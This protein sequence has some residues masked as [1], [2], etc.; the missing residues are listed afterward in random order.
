MP[1]DQSPDAVEAQTWI[2]ARLD[3]LAGTAVGKIDAFF[4]DE[5][6]GRPEWLVVRLGRF[7]QHGL[8]PAREAVGVAGRVWVPYPREAIKAAPKA[9]TKAPLTREAELELLKHFGA[10]GNAG[11]TAELSARGFEAITAS[12]A[13]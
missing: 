6:S 12:P 8:V 10:G 3:D 13:S 4:V 2:G 7:G 5:D 11:R 9:G 1:E